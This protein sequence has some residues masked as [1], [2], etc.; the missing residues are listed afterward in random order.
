MGARESFCVAF[1]RASI[2]NCEVSEMF[3]M[4]VYFSSA[5][6]LLRVRV[7]AAQVREYI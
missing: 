7:L 2:I 1:V 4:C 5:Y 3:T 6:V